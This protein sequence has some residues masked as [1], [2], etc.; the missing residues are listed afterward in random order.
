MGKF[1]A[2]QRPSARRGSKSRC[3]PASEPPNSP[4]TKSASPVLGPATQDALVP[5]HFA[6]QRNG[7]QKPL[8]IATGFAA[9]DGDAVALGQ[10]VDAGVNALDKIGIKVFRQRER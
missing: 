4:V 10:S 5:R 3:L 9:D 2:S 1:S 7:E 6:Q 8:R